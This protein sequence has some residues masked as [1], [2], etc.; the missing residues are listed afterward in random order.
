MSLH[1][2]KSRYCSAVQC[3]K[4]L[5][6][7]VNKPDVVD[8]A[9]IPQA[10]LDRGNAVGDLAMGLFGDYVEVTFGD[11]SEMCRQTEVLIQ[12]GTPVIAEASF[13][14]NGLFCSVDL[15]RIL[16]GNKVELVE[17]KSSTHVT[18]IYL[19][20]VAFQNY[21]LTQL[22]YDV[23]RVTI[24]HINTEYVRQGELEL[25]RL[26]A[27][28]DVTNIAREKRQSVENRIAFLET[29]MQAADE[30]KDPIGG[31]CFS[32]Y[33]CAFFPYCTRDLPK[34]NIFDV[35]GLQTR[36]RLS[37]YQKGI[38][39]FE[40]I[41][42]NK[43][44]NANALLQVA[45][46]LHDLPPVIDQKAIQK[47]LAGLSYP[48]YFLDF[49]SFQPAIPLYDNSCP[50]EQIVF[51]YSLH[52]IEAE[53]A[54]LQHCEYLAWPGEDPRRGVAKQLCRDIPTDVCV[55]AY[56][57]SFEKGRIRAL[58]ALYPDLSEHLMNIHDAAGA[59]LCADEPAVRA[60][61]HTA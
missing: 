52:F 8:E 35:A 6:L 40:D 30:P 44:V 25:D 1:L 48:L 51:Q 9:L 59:G 24:A 43:A 26:F 29:Y 2:S 15:L 37:N 47:F 14:W 32:P 56:N 54:P 57:M 53:G 23:Q 33:G 61:L 58:A 20:D 46:T 50:Y 19:E 22:G 45:H 21:L 12:L 41:E 36:T 28:E 60:Q 10:V 4:Q 27:I 55:L 18:P 11:L 39:S 17:V 7:K 31:H 3:P 16:G 5:W 42:A 34:P 49:E 13:A 38:V